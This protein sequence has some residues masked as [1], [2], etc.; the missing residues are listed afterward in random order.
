MPPVFQEHGGK[1]RLSVGQKRVPAARRHLMIPGIKGGSEGRARG[2]LSSFWQYW[3]LARKRSL[4]EYQEGEDAD[5]KEKEGEFGS[6]SISG[7]RKGENRTGK[8]C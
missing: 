3:I 7:Y 5:S 4:N 8:G 6:R 2:S 1:K